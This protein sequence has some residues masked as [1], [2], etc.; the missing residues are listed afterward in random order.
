MVLKLFVCKCFF[1]VS[2]LDLNASVWLFEK[3][4]FYLLLALFAL[5]AEEFSLEN[6]IY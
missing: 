5:E 1:P 3:I 4:D 6:L 2:N